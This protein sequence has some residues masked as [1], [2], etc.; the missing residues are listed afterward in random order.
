VRP[1]QVKILPDRER[2]R[3]RDI[4]LDS[5]DDGEEKS[6]ERTERHKETQ[7]DTERHKEGRRWSV[8]FTD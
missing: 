8:R 4:L 1:S 3:D 6:H 7:R 2:Q 5:T